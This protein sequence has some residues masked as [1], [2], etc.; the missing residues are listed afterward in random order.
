M[1]ENDIIPQPNGLDAIIIG[2]VPRVL[3]KLSPDPMKRAAFPPF[4]QAAPTVP[5][6]DWVDIDRRI[7]LGDEYILDQKSHGSCVGFSSAHALM[8]LRKIEGMPYVKLSGAFVYSYINGGQ[9]NGA[10]ISDSLT[11]LLLPPNGNG[12]GTCTEAEAPWDA[13]YPSRIPASARTTALRFGILEAYKANNFAELVSGIQLGSIG[14]GAVMVGSRFSTLDSNGVA[15]F[16]NG[17]GNH[18][19]CFDGVKRLPSGEWVLDLPNTWGLS[20]GER[21]RCRV[22]QRHIESVEIDNYLI[23]AATAD[24][25]DPNA[26]P[27]AQGV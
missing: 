1:K 11:E 16:D 24:P 4:L 9:D 18:S 6:S 27:P 10:I 15:G 25:Q 5:E 20:F 8:R 3:A 26:P 2:G 13:I 21:G 22:T 17:P 7:E 14:V 19:V 23:R 12:H